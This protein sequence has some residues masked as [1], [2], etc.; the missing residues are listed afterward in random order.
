MELTHIKLSEIKPGSIYKTLCTSYKGWD[1]FSKWEGD[2][3]QFDKDIHDF[4]SSIGSSGFGTLLGEKLVGFVSWDPRQYP[5]YSIIGHNC[6]L[7]R[8]RNQGIGKHQI[9]L[10]L[11][12]FQKDG[13]QNTRVSTKRD[14]FFKNARKMYESCGFVECTPYRNDGENMIYYSIELKNH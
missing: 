10:A 3:L 5:L 12:E 6:I 13:F 4:P 7:P 11:K 8:Y 9:T 14:N 2:W 1:E